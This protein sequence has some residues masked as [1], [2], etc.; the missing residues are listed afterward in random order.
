MILWVRINTR[1]ECLEKCALN[2]PQE[3]RNQA[4]VTFRNHMALEVVVVLVW[5]QTVKDVDG[6]GC[7]SIVGVVVGFVVLA[8]YCLLYTSDAADE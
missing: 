2:L 1:D 3:E 8:G 4:E 5:K 6:D 7:M